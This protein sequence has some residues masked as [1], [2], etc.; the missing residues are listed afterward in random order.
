M[1]FIKKFRIFYY[2]NFILFNYLEKVMIFKNSKLL[3]V[4]LSQRYFNSRSTV[5]THILECFK[6]F[7]PFRCLGKPR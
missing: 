1:Y 7:D 2:Q 3:M 4:N 6:S 5:E